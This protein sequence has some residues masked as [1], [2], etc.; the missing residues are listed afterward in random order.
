MFG[1]P[2]VRALRRRR[3]VPLI[4]L[5]LNVVV[6]LATAPCGLAA[7]S[8]SV[9]EDASETGGRESPTAKAGPGRRDARDKGKIFDGVVNL[10]TAPPA[11]LL[12]LPGVG[13][14]RVRGILTYRARRPFRTVDELVRVTGD[15]RRMVREIRP[16][17]AVTG[18]S[19][20]RGGPAGASALDTLN[21]L[22]AAHP[23]PP[24]GLS[25]PPLCRPN[26]VML[27]ARAAATRGRPRPVR[28]AANRCAAPP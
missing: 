22:A 7:E 16:H 3:I 4:A 13:P 6:G 18:P 27:L 15:G 9:G 21:S 19:T 17:L 25:R 23:L 2:L 20:A 28:S 11:L 5:A 24:A 10:N 26:P 12:L 1:R 8:G 14:G